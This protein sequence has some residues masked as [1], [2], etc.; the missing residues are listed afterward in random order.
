MKSDDIS[1]K[2]VYKIEITTVLRN[3]TVFTKHQFYHCEPVFVFFLISTILGSIV[4]DTV[5]RGK[6]M[7]K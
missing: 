7:Y 5:Q 1:L 2:S 6:G 4:A 3:V